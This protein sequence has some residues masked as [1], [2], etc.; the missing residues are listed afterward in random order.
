MKNEQPL[1]ELERIKIGRHEENDV[2]LSPTDI[3]RFHAVI[4]VCG[5]NNYLIQDLESKH[6]TFVN[7]GRIRSKLIC[8]EDEIRLASHTV[9]AKDLLI[10]A[11]VIE[12]EKPKRDPD[13]FTEE[14]AIMNEFYEQYLIFKAEEI[15]IQNAIKKMNDN[16]R[17]GGALSAPTLAAL[18]LLLGGAPAVAAMSACGLGMLI[19]AIGS[20]FLGENEKLSQPRLHF[21]N[22]WKCP[23]CGDKTMLLGKSWQVLAKQKKCTR[24]NA[25]WV[26]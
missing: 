3:G 5:P 23:R 17:L 24:C 9:L 8:A 16:L 4:T 2:V 7:E 20:R 26:K 1:L 15:N 11:K 25:V 18:T 22:N 12:G 10:I 21:A 6:G 14:F 13:D 19:P